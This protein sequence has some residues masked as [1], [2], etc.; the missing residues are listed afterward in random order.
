MAPGVA[1]PDRLPSVQ[2]WS[3]NAAMLRMFGPDCL[4]E[5]ADPAALKAIPAGVRWIDLLNPTREEEKLAEQALGQ[6]IPT[7]EEMVEIEPSSR[8]YVRRGA[9]FMTASV[10]HGITEG[11]PNTDPI[12]FIL[13]DRLLVTVRYVDPLPFIKFTEHLCAEPELAQE[14]VSILARLLDVI[15]DR[16]AD[17][18]EETAKAIEV[19]SA[20]VFEHRRKVGSLKT[21]VRLE[22][23]LM[24]IGEVQ[25]LL[26]EVRESAL[27][28]SRMLS[29]L[30]TSKLCRE[31]DQMAFVESLQ[32]DAHALLDH[33]NFLTDN[34]GFLLNA[35]LGLI[36]LEQNFVMKV[37]SVFA[38]VLMPP[39]LIA[40]IYGMNF[41]HMPELR[42][43]LGYPFAL[44]LIL[45]SA[46]VPY[47][48]ARRS[49][50]L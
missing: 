48:L 18:L 9:L 41:E 17:E 33:N 29:F 35:S 43:L 31:S 22:A 49:G 8:L 10:I 37:F 12:S 50:W 23:L 34:L 19:L 2:R 20:R 6:N 27:S 28:T 26:S 11:Q 40:G 16:L 13:T 30:G 46:V 5:P 45:L 42:W 21:E 38:V 47:W 32:S 15:V 3:T 1:W 44:G 25:R 4:P 39:T 36:T 24:R 14:P 7:R